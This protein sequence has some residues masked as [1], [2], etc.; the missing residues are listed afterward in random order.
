MGII[1]LKYSD[2]SITTKSEIL[3][4]L[5]ELGFNW[6]IDSEVEN[7]IIEIKKDTLIW[8][9]GIFK[10]GDWKYGIFKNGAFFG[11]FF[12]GYEPQVFILFCI[13]TTPNKPIQ[14]NA[15]IDIYIILCITIKKN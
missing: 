14:N 10:Y 11:F 3:K 7:A 6:L 15:N 8:H 13:T 1:E 9:E 2:K 12:P 4:K 5:K